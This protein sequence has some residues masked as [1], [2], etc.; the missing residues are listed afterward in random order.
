MPPNTKKTISLNDK[1]NG[2]FFRRA[3][4]E[5]LELGQKDLRLAR[6]LWSALQDS[7]T[8][9]VEPTDDSFPLILEADK[10]GKSINFPIKGLIDLNILLTINTAWEYSQSRKDLQAVIPK[11]LD[12]FR[13]QFKNLSLKILGRT[14]HNYG[15]R[16]QS[17]YAI[18]Y[19]EL[20]H[21]AGLPGIDLVDELSVAAIENLK[22]LEDER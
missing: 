13:R 16:S 14:P 8:T 10:I 11:A 5:I 15:S 1:T 22:A 18:T 7:A 12:S 9:D 17:R 20:L 4:D 2:D 6:R 21:I 19:A 3:V